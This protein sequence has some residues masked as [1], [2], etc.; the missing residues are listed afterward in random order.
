[1]IRVLKLY[2]RPT[3]LESG[4]DPRICFSIDDA[5][6]LLEYIKLRAADL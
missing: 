4:K 5:L 3:K 6:V 1:M 2:P